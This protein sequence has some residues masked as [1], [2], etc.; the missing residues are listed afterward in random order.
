MPLLKRSAGIALALIVLCAGMSLV[1]L[2]TMPSHAQAAVVDPGSKDIADPHAGD[3]DAPDGDSDPTN[4][5]ISNDGVRGGSGG[6]HDPGVSVGR[7]PAG[8]SPHRGSLWA[9]WRSLIS[10]WTRWSFL[11]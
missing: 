9:H 4:G 10:L 3:P 7:I 2:C 6:S 8:G 1:T 5:H 11:R